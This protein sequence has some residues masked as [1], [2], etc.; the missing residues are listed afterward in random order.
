MVATKRP[1][2]VEQTHHLRFAGIRCVSRL[3]RAGRHRPHLPR[4]AAY[5]LPPGGS[6]RS[7]KCSQRG[8]ARRRRSAPLRRHQCTGDWP[9]PTGS[10]DRGWVLRSRSR[11][12]R[13]H[14]PDRSRHRRIT[15]DTLPGG[16]IERAV[17]YHAPF[18]QCDREQ[19]YR[20]A[21]QE[22]EAR[23]RNR[24]V[25]DRRSPRDGLAR[26]TKTPP[27]RLCPPVPVDGTATP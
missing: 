18:D 10:R 12:N 2:P 20:T 13:C 26:E 19:D 22:F 14:R 9:R 27:E 3:A 23:I 16:S 15:D 11:R 7:V 4:V 25:A 21:C 17:E 1:V 8:G 24:N 5:H 6:A